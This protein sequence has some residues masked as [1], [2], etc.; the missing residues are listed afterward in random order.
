MTGVDSAETLY[1]T[2]P[3]AVARRVPSGLMAM[4]GTMPLEPAAHGVPS[5]RCVASVQWAK[6]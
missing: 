3:E 6:S 5:S 4:E 2:P 1:V